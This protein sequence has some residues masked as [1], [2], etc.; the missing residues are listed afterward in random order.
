MLLRTG[1]TGYKVCK[2]VALQGAFS[3]HVFMLQ[4]MKDKVARV[5][6]VRTAKDLEDPSLDA[7]V[8][9]G[10]ESTT[11]SLIAERTNML[12]PLSKW[13][14]E[15]KKPVWGTCAGMILLANGV[16]QGRAEGQKQ[17]GGLDVVVKRNAFGRQA[18]SF[19][20][21]LHIPVLDDASRPFQGVFIRAPV[22]EIVKDSTVET[23]VTVKSDRLESEAVV[24]VRQGNILAT[25]FHPELT[26]DDRFHRYFVDWAQSLTSRSDTKTG[27]V[28][29]TAMLGPASKTTQF[30]PSSLDP[31]PAPI[32]QM[33]AA[34]SIHSDIDTVGKPQLK[35]PLSQQANSI[36]A[37]LLKLVR[38]YIA[39]PQQQQGAP[40][41]DPKQIEQQVEQVYAFCKR[42]LGSRIKAPVVVDDNHAVDVIKKK[43][44]RRDKTPH[45]AIQFSNLWTKF[46][47]KT[48]VQQKWASLYFLS[49]LFDSQTTDEPK[50]VFD[51][52]F[53]LKGL[54]DVRQETT[55]KPL[56]HS[57][58]FKT[59]LKLIQDNF[60]AQTALN[61]IDLYY[62]KPTFKGEPVTE[63]DILR[64]VM[65]IFQGIDGRIIH[66]D[67]SSDAVYCSPEV[68][69]PGSTMEL[70]ARICEVGFL[71]RKIQRFLETKEKDEYRGLVRQSFCA[72][73]QQEQRE[74]FEIIASLENHLSKDE[75]NTHFATRGLS[76]KRLNVWVNEP[77]QKLRFFA[78]LID[79][80]E[81]VKGGA[82]LS[83]IYSYV[84]HGDPFVRNII[85]KLLKEVTKPFF[86]MLGRWIYE[87][88]LDDPYSEFF[89][90]HDKN[91]DGDL[92]RNAYK[93]RNEMIPLFMQ[94][95]AAKKAF[96]IGKSLNFIRY[97]C[98]DE[99][100]VLSRRLELTKL[101]GAGLQYGDEYTLRTLIESSYTSIS[102][103]LLDMFFTKYDL[104]KHLNAL[105]KYLLLGQ[106]DFIHSL[107][108]KLG[109]DLS[110]PAH[111]LLRHNLT[112]ILES[113]IRSSNA[114]EEDPDIWKRLDVRLL[115]ISPGDSGWDIF[116]LDY[117]ISG[118]LTTVLT[119]QVMHEY[120]KLFT[121]LWRLKRVEFALSSCWRTQVTES[122]ELMRRSKMEGLKGVLQ[123]CALVRH[124]MQ[125]FVSQLQ[126]YILFE[127]LESAWNQLVGYLNKRSGDL[128][129]LIGAHNHFINSITSC[130]L[131][132]ASSNASSLS[133][134]ARLVKLFEIILKFETVQSKMFDQALNALNTESQ[135][136]ALDYERRLTRSFSYGG[137][138]GLEQKDNVEVDLDAVERVAGEFETEFKDMLQVLEGHADTNLHGLHVRLDYNEFYKKASMVPLGAG[139]DVGR[140]CLILTIGNKNIM[141]DCGMHMG[142]SDSRRY[143][144]FSYISKSGQ[145]NQVLDCIII[146]HFHLD[147]CGAL[148]YF[149]EVCGYDGPIYMT[150][151]TRAIAPILLDDMRK[152]VVERKG[153]TN[154][155]T[156]DDVRNCMSKVIPVMLHETVFVDEELEIKPYYA[157]HVLGAAMF[158]VK[159]GTESIVYTGD[160]NMTPDRHLGAAWIDKCCPDLLIT[161]TTYATT[162][163]ASKRS[164]EQDFLHSVHECVMKGGKVLV[165]VFALGRAQE[166]CI[167]LDSYWERTNMKVP[168]YFTAGLMERANQYYK[169]FIGWTN[170]KIKQ[171]FVDRNMFDFKHIKSFE[172]Y[173]IDEP[174]PMVLF[175][176]PGM[177]HAGTS[178]DVFKKW[179]GDAKNMI[180]LPGYCVPGTVGAKV[181]AGEKV[182]EVDKLTRLN[183]NI[184]VRNLSFSAHADSKGIMQLIHMCQ[185]RNVMLVHGEARKMAVLK[186]K[187][188][189]DFRIPC[190]DPANGE[191]VGIET[192]QSMPAAISEAIVQS[193]MTKVDM[194]KKQDRKAGKASDWEL[195]LAQDDSS[196]YQTPFSGGVLIDSKGDIPIV[197]DKKTAQEKLQLH[198]MAVKFRLRKAYDPRK[199]TAFAITQ[200]VID[201]HDKHGSGPNVIADHPGQLAL[202][203]VATALDRWANVS[204]VGDDLPIK[205][206]I[207]VLS[208]GPMVIFC[209]N[210]PEYSL[211]IE[212]NNQHHELAAKVFA[213]ISASL[214]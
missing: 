92:W 128:D 88:E 15:Q 140:S 23:I 98:G 41:K 160:Y 190:Y 156:A 116:A 191:T 102:R 142:Y 122:I 123:R 174:G 101:E 75:T 179:C 149:T 115:E 96:L 91:A 173:L 24:G 1:V 50:T 55:E 202:H 139:Q 104:T 13:V 17:I 3:E 131:F 155:F 39:V 169:L 26:N 19:V 103:Y 93:L 94:R 196:E 125:H 165:P 51:D 34:F 81:G 52:V 105:K 47:S 180:I 133:V 2:H 183:V 12:E 211:F 10:G 100:F 120:L 162:I 53:A 35:D 153:D 205:L 31:S 5:V 184:Q 181:L 74:F 38:Y 175:A 57:D 188:E 201:S 151:P 37:A 29:D 137:L 85:E 66:L 207:G 97:V 20:A 176:S 141:L 30:T 111:T 185:P 25:A 56:E 212:W 130:G 159:V 62:L 9:P 206:D 67:S 186:K 171:T 80:S 203:I 90:A 148:P 14:R 164:R 168:I 36:N 45:T 194:L 127:V 33:S 54:K 69:L 79:A 21:D 70:I 117:H 138:S 177:L 4:R 68:T 199:V 178:L 77:L 157:G 11:M 63:S 187:I 145:F 163:R 71:Y 170:E 192:I 119:S 154:F 64:D 107:M 60:A 146:S 124:E 109:H 136:Q 210:Q 86:N 118:P 204:S 150:H 44:V 48:V 89:V 114:V 83:V 198:P 147:H 108:D 152:V 27:F 213:V 65:Y 58:I 143:P 87:G 193:I 200:S 172:R 208:V 6:E 22:I 43:F 110:K 42:I 197:Y 158:H 7:L 121:F 78:V 214:Q 135:S 82:L 112:G 144:D 113:S 167:L 18:D 99:G 49:A 84:N 16:S 209:A 28:S 76:L 134:F 106:G 59:Q 8:L 72:G 129:Q 132:A 166:L 40:S 189:A 73:L 61:T 95:S 32:P 182:I 195:A 161:E 126:Y 46:K